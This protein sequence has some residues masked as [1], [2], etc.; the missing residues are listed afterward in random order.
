L[1]VILWGLTFTDKPIGLNLIVEERISREKTEQLILTKVLFTGFYSFL[2]ESMRREGYNVNTMKYYCDGYTLDWNPSKTG[3]GYSI[4]DEHGSLLE[5]KVINKEGFTNNEAEILGIL[6][7]LEMCEEGDQVSTDSM[8]SLSWI[9][10]GSAKARPDLN[11]LL[12]KC[13]ELLGE[14]R[15]NLMWERRDFNL[16]GHFNEEHDTASKKF[17]KIKENKKRKLLL[18]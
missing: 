9:N 11:P 5:H 15:I 6:G 3:G 18:V 10:K 8:C 13:K 4:V 16:A 14:K 2:D 17:K 1:R 12:S 7:T